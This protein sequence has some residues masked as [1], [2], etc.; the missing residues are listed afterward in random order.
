MGMFA[1]PSVPSTIRS[2]VNIEE[3]Q[4]EALDQ[5][6]VVHYK[7]GRHIGGG[8]FVIEISSSVKNL[9]IA[10]FDVESPASFLI[11]I[12]FPRAQEIVEMFEHNFEL[13]SDYLNFSRNK[14]VMLN[15][16]TTSASHYSLGNH[17]KEKSGVRYRPRATGSRN[18]ESER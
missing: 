9:F 16:V 17:E 5:N 13:M 1:R 11:T 18:H 6:R 15:P 8:Y 4:A 12:P 14:L 2:P 10:A 7:K 3:R